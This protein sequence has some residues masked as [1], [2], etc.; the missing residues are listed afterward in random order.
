MK[1]RDAIVV[2]T[3][4]EKF[5]TT[6]VLRAT[7]GGRFPYALLMAR[8]V[9]EARKRFA[10]ETVV[11]VVVDFQMDGA[12]ALWDEICRLA[13]KWKVIA[14]CGDNDDLQEPAE[15][16]ILRNATVNLVLAQFPQMANAT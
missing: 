12:A 15:A 10:T 1:K 5:V 11:V 8:S 13:S 14:L 6:L 9:E 16:T 3:T 2:V 7:S 4:N